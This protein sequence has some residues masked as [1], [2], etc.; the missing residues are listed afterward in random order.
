M[1]M[2]KILEKSYKRLSYRP[3]ETAKSTVQLEFVINIVQDNN[4]KS[5]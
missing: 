5:R 2:G 1:R 3:E 4:I